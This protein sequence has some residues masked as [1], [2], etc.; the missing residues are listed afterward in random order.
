MRSH[1]KTVVFFIPTFKQ[2]P[3]G[4]T[5]CHNGTTNYISFHSKRSN[6][7][8]EHIQF[9]LILSV[10]YKFS[11]AIFVFFS[12]FSIYSVTVDGYKGNLD[13][14][15]L[16]S[17]NLGAGQRLGIETLLTFIVVLVYLMSTDSYKSYFGVSSLTIGAAYGAC[18]FVSVRINCYL[19]P[20]V[21]SENVQGKNCYSWWQSSSNN[22]IKENRKVATIIIMKRSFAAIQCNISRLP[23][24]IWVPSWLLLIANKTLHFRQ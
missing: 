1:F 13:A 12:S 10:L 15:I 16:H 3:N 20:T 4:F 6:N 21:C 11:I 7:K 14:V 23:A 24:G 9:F 2:L 18:S 22:K 17:A 5:S 8:K 19:L